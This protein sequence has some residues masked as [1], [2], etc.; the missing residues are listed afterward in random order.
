MMPVVV[1]L[2]R[3]SR[4]LPLLFLL[5]AAFEGTLSLFDAR[6]VAARARAVVAA[7]QAVTAR[8]KVLALRGYIRSHVSKE[9]YPQEGRPFL[10]A[11]AGEVLRS[12][13]GWCGEDTRLFICMAAAVGVPAQRINLYGRLQHTL[14]EAEIG[15]HER[16][17]VDC[18]NPPI[19]KDLE[20]LDRVILRPEYDD[21]FTL[22]LR[23]LQVQW[24]VTR[25]KLQMGPLTYWTEQPHALK[26][27]LWLLLAAGLF[28]A[29][30]AR[31]GLRTF[32]LRRG[33]M[34]VST[35]SPSGEGP[36][37]EGGLALP[38]A[39]TRNPKTPGWWPRGNASRDAPSAPPRDSDLVV[40]R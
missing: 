34:H 3:V 18:F 10:R 23:R 29:H 27:F 4:A 17:V 25:V 20:P 22:N 1:T 30:L 38:G 37:D 5:L 2:R 15:P 12:G 36:R 28:A 26:A 21:Y 9:G 39:R 11:T 32:L 14:A 16:A 7:A 19:V 13:K 8:E 33:W 40:E 31:R 24:L 35:L 6:F